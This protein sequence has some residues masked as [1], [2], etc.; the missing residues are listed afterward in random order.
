MHTQTHIY[1]KQHQYDTDAIYQ[2]RKLF[3]KKLTVIKPSTIICLEAFLIFAPVWVYGC[4]MIM[5]FS[6]DETTYSIHRIRIGNRIYHYYIYTESTDKQLKFHHLFKLIHYEFNIKTQISFIGVCW[7]W[8][9]LNP[10]SALF[11]RSFWLIFTDNCLICFKSNLYN[12]EKQFHLF[13]S[14]IKQWRL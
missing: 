13:M 6:K 7:L 5:Q 4:N 1:T 2:I 3:R 14:L 10:F 12:Q 11:F 9:I 8:L